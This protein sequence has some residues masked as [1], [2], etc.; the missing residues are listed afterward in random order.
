VLAELMTG[1]RPIGMERCPED[2]N[3]ATY[4][5]KAKK[6]DR[7]H[8]ILD[9]QNVQETTDEQLKAACDLL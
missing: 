9:R 2:R 7:L 8:E 1:K 6:E 5:V 3:L 4:F